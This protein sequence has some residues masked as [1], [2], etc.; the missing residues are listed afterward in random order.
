[1]PAVERANL[2][3]DW[4]ISPVPE[5]AHTNARSLLT[6]DERVVLIQEW[7]ARISDLTVP[8]PLKMPPER[9]ISHE[10]NF[11]DPN[12]LPNYHQP[13]C[14]D[15]LR[16]ELVEKIERY[17][18]AGWWVRANVP[19][20]APLLCVYKKDR[21]LRTVVDARKRNDNTTKDVTPFPDQDCIRHD[22]ARAKYR[23]KLDMSDAYEQIRVRDSDVHKTAFSTIFG[24]FVSKVMQQGDDNAPS[25]FQRLMTY[26]FHDYI[27]RFVHVYL[28]DIFIYSDSVKEHNEH[29]QLVFDRLRANTLYLS[30]KKVDLFS[31]RMD[32][33]GHIIDDNGIHPDA[34]K[35]RTIR[36]WP[37]PRNYHDIQ[38][39]LRMVQYL[40]PFMP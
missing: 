20:A 11:I 25:T 3:K 21:R 8:V 30:A 38:R 2:I 19:S 14:P 26:I 9:D 24:T 36:E 37:T 17:T 5:F 7:T 40:A 32:C 10:I 27:G 29:L 22:V 28:D 13:R 31:V 33:L 35:L 23:S 16:E 12:Y 34:D 15:V 6:H 18:K 4:A 1:M 39:Y